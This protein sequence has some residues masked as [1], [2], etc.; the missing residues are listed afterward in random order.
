L[1]IEIHPPLLN[2]LQLLTLGGKREVTSPEHR[3][4]ARPFVAVLTSAC[5]VVTACSE[6]AALLPC[7]SRN[8][9]P[10]HA[11]LPSPNIPFLN[12]LDSRAIRS[13]ISQ[14]FVRKAVALRLPPSAHKICDRSSG[15]FPVPRPI[16]FRN[17]QT[18]EEMDSSDD[19]S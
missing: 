12:I 14:S 2:R 13:R 7:V 1:I 16:V 8:A 6:Q 17:R 15:K 18:A 9:N 19:S 10:L 11:G 5:H 3:S 4:I